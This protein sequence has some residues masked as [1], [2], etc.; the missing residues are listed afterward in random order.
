L[1]TSIIFGGKRLKIPVIPS[2]MSCVIDNKLA[3]FLS[4]NDYGYIFHRFNGP[5]NQKDLLW[6]IERANEENWKL[7]SISIGVQS[8]DRE[9]LSEIVKRKLRV[10]W[11]TID[12]AHGFCDLLR[13][14]AFYTR[15]LFPKVFLIAG[16]IA[17][18]EATK[19]YKDWSIGAAK[20]GVGKGRACLST[21]KTKFGTPMFSTIRNICMNGMGGTYSSPLP[22]IADGGI[23]ENGDI[24]AALVA[25]AS[26]V[27]AGSI[28]AA[29][30]DSPAENIYEEEIKVEAMGQPTE[31]I[32]RG[33]TIKKY[34]FGSASKYNGNSKNIEGDLIEIPCNGMTYQEKLIE[35]QE[36]I[37]SAMSYGG[38]QHIED[39]RNVKWNIKYS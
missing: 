10:D 38:C 30:I 25:G 32:K 20:V 24:I 8:E 14:M 23:R 21:S 15:I 22:I 12:I 17:N 28:F 11:I 26:I 16:N 4:E 5:Q 3:K 39:F 19:D 13:S 34:Y 31:V 27:C 35:L 29:C 2:N 33:K 18:L 37:S 7:I 1:D 36:D 9:L 6:F